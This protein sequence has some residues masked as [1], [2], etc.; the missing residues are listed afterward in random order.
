MNSAGEAASY[1]GV[2]GCVFQAETGLV[3]LSNFLSGG[4]VQQ[5][6]VT[7]SLHAV[8]MPAKTETLRLSWN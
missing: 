5:V 2:T 8:I 1:S 3:S 4:D 6:I 7:E